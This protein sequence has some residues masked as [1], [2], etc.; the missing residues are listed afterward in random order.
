MFILF[1][2]CSITITGM[3]LQGDLFFLLKQGFIS[4]KITSRNSKYTNPCQGC[5]TTSE[6]M[7]FQFSCS[8]QKYKYFFSAANFLVKLTCMTLI[9]IVREPF[10]VSSYKFE[11]FYH[12]LETQN[13]LQLVWLQAGN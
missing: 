6:G 9:Y 7:L 3:N 4:A 13:V 12:S 8:P 10:H 5:L 1:S 2:S 11:P